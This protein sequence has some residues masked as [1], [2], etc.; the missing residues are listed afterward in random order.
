MLRGPLIIGRDT[1]V[2]D[3]FVGPHTAID[4]DCRLKGVRIGGSIVLEH[5]TI[6]DIHW[7]IEH[8]LIGRHVILRGGSAVGG[9]YSLTL[10]DHS[11]IQMPDA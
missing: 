1:E 2:T 4:H 5:S 7:P 6:E 8:S 9:S 10:G 11:Q 3:S